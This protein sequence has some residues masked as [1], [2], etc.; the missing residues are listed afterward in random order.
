MK[1]LETY[2]TKFS[3]YE[4]ERGENAYTGEW[5]F[6]VEHFENI[7]D[8]FEKVDRDDVI[9][10]LQG[11]TTKETIVEDFSP[12]KLEGMHSLHLEKA[13]QIRYSSYDSSGNS[14]IFSC[15]VAAAVESI[16]QGNMIE[17]EFS[18]GLT[19]WSND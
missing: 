17:N 10:E 4:K 3:E 8:Y 12:I 18:K 7:K 14:N 16:M 9:G 13:M 5:K 19:K 15:Y 11:K 2:T 6:L 1:A